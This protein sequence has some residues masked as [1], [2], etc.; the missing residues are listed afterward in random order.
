MRVEVKTI[1]NGLKPRVEIQKTRNAKDDPSSRLY[2]A[3]QF[4]VIAVCIG[5]LTGDWS[6]FRY[7]FASALPRH[8]KFP[9]KLK[10]MHDV[11]LEQPGAIRW[12]SRLQEVIDD[13]E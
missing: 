11:P 3:D 10:I 9:N 6:Q 4:D 8:D 7:A 13:L 2:S 5:R 12:F 1:R